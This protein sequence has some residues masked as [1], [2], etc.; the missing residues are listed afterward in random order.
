MYCKTIRDCFE[1]YSI[2]FKRFLQQKTYYNGS[3][4]AEVSLLP[5]KTDLLTCRDGFFETPEDVKQDIIKSLGYE[6]AV[7]RLVIVLLW[8]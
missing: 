7:L 6:S 8:E 5:E 4:N 1:P 2:V 3:D